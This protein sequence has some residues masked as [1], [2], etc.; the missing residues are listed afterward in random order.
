MCNISEG[1]RKSHRFYTCC[2][3]C[4]GGETKMARDSQLKKYV[5]FAEEEGRGMRD[6]PRR[7]CCVADL[8]RCYISQVFQ[9][10]SVASRAVLQR[11]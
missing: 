5:S 4:V 6:R 3:R 2:R 10:V 7:T 1:L 9:T 11:R 8:R